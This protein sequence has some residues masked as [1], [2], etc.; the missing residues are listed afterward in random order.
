MG[1]P[2]KTVT[3]DAINNRRVTRP[4]ENDD[5]T[6]YRG[7]AFFHSVKWRNDKTIGKGKTFYL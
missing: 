3:K 4:A 6:P 7:I 5:N 1:T 2:R